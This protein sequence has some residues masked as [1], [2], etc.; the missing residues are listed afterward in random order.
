MFNRFENIELTYDVENIFYKDNQV[1]SYLR[2]HYFEETIK[3]IT[4]PYNEKNKSSFF[5]KSLTLL[6]ESL[7]GFRH[8]FGS[9]DYLVFSSSANRQLIDGLY[10]EKSFERMMKLIGQDKFLLIEEAAPEHYPKNLVPTKHI[11]SRNPL[12]LVSGL[13]TRVFFPFYR[14]D[15][16]IETL[17][18]INSKEE[19]KV[20]YQSII[21]RFNIV[22][23]IMKFFLKI[24]TPKVIFVSCYYGKQEIVKAAKELDIKVVEAQ[25]GMIGS[26]HFGYNLNKQF[27]SAFFPDVLLTYGTYDKNIIKE[28]ANN[29]FHRLYA[30]GSDVLEQIQQH[31]G[32]QNLQ[33]L[34]NKYKYSLSVSTQYTVEDEVALFVRSLAL[35]HKDICFMFSLRHFEKVYYEKFDLPENVYLFKGEYSCYDILKV[36]DA[37]LSVYSTCALEAL[38]FDKKSILLNVHNLATQTMEDIVNDNLYIIEDENDFLR[39]YDKDFKED[40]I[41]IYD[42]NYEKNLKIFMD[43][44]L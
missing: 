36:S 8:W 9:Y 10:R 29:P 41:K 42:K 20:A 26:K 28:N 6:K 17:E 33:K 39:V 34:V 16:T 7:Y 15:F 23:N 2:N 19:C 32:P 30:L 11:V 21:I 1:W 24:Y 35:K 18:K 12:S 31:S 14:Q 25:H 38:F 37:H 13:L 4:A 3:T 22:K 40:Q 43:R 27:D 44:E 5:I